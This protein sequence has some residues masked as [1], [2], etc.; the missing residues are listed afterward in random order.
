MTEST[1]SG[2]ETVQSVTIES[3]VKKNGVAK[4]PADFGSDGNAI[5]LVSSTKNALKKQGWPR[6]DISAFKKLALAGDYNCVIT[7]CLR[8]LG[9]IRFGKIVETDD[10]V[11][12]KFYK[13]TLNEILNPKEET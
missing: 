2:Q 8:V 6:E 9:S 7:S 4:M 13:D 1:D 5:A 3:L 12:M 10:T 11:E